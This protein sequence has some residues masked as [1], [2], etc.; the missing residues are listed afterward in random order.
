MN[1][2]T[3]TWNGCQVDV[4]PPIP[5]GLTDQEQIDLVIQ[6]IEVLKTA[7]ENG[8]SPTGIFGWR[9]C[10][11]CISALN[12]EG[13]EIRCELCLVVTRTGQRCQHGLHGD[14]NQDGKI[15]A[16]NSVLDRLREHR[17]EMTDEDNP[18]PD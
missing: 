17:K 15:S 13:N 2:C 18:R 11:F 16:V 6:K 4:S 7:I 9:S 3:F 8:A 5:T 12:K 10:A 1:E 14:T